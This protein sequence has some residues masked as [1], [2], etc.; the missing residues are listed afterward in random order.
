MET[1]NPTWF[2]IS[3]D[4]GTV[5]ISMHHNNPPCRFVSEMGEKDIVWCLWV[6]DGT[7]ACDVL[8]QQVPTNVELSEALDRIYYKYVTHT[9]SKTATTLLPYDHGEVF[10]NVFR[11]MGTMDALTTLARIW[12]KEIISSPISGDDTYYDYLPDY[13]CGLWQLCKAIDGKYIYDEVITYLKNGPY[14]GDVEF[15]YLIIRPIF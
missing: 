7:F 8:A 10:A 6:W 1:T 13:T 9:P 2:D 3:N 14:K 15:K 12:A 5:L 4:G 11:I